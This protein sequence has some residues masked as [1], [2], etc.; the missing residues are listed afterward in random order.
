MQKCAGVFLI[1]VDYS[2]IVAT[3]FV[4]IGRHLDLRP[5]AKSNSLARRL[6][7]NGLNPMECSFEFLA[8]GPLFPEQQTIEHHRSFRDR[9][10]ALEAL[11]AN[12][13]RDRGYEVIGIHAS[14][15]KPTAAD[16]AHLEKLIDEF[17]AQ[18]RI[19]RF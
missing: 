12:E 15:G 1:D 3:D 10:G 16:A 4:R 17:P 19:G 6:R 2:N 7:D 9:T 8:L 5:N 14:R 18:E 11:L 13:L